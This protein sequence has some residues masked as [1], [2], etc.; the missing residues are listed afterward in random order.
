MSMC[1]QLYKIT[2]LMMVGFINIL[3]KC[4]CVLLC[5]FGSLGFILTS[6]RLLVIQEL[7]ASA[8]LFKYILAQCFHF[9]VT[10]FTMK[11]YCYVY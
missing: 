6:K 4:I 11:Y 1:M 3:S 2:Y 10:V 5:V 7:N 9:A 8:E